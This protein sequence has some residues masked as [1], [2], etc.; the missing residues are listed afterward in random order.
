MRRTL[1]VLVISVILMLLALVSS[2]G[3]PGT[4]LRVSYIDVGQGD[5][6]WLRAWDGTDILIDG[7]PAA[8]GPTVVAYL[9]EDNIDDIDVMVLSHAYEDHVGGLIGVLQSTI[10]VEAVI[11]NGQP[12]AGSPYQAFVTELQAQGITPTPAAAGQEYAWGPIS[13]TVLNPQS[14]PTGAQ[15][16]DSVVLRVVD[17]QVRFL[18]TGDVTLSAEKAI[19]DS[20]VDVAAEIPKVAHHG[21]RYSSSTAFLDATSAE[22]AIISA[23]TGNPYGHPAEET[24]TRL[25]AAGARVFRTDLHGTV[26]VVSDGTTYDVQAG[27][28]LAFLPLIAHPLPPKVS[29][30]YPSSASTAQGSVSVAVVG[31]NF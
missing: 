26:V 9:Q 20:G 13:A 14:T 8:A 25:R 5:S 15:N 19:L 12:H 4:T 17:D 16:E 29:G 11:I 7:G 1:V 6:V 27:G 23:G 18:F 28:F 10:P 22:V 3:S 30:V 2:V 24:L 21:G 31:A